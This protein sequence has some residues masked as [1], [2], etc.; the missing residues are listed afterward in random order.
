MV[1]SM[2]QCEVNGQYVYIRDIDDIYYYLRKL[3]NDDFTDI[4][5]DTVVDI[6]DGK[7]SEKDDKIH[8]LEIDLEEAQDEIEGLEVEAYSLQEELEKARETISELQ[9]VINEYKYQ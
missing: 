1:L 7:L 4:V 5:V 9:E 2:E 8:W 3:T 6:I